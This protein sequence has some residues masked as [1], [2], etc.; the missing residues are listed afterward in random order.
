MRCG[1]LPAQVLTVIFALLF[2]TIASAAPV[3]W[4][5]SGVQF[6]DGGMASGSFTYD[7][8]TD[9]LTVWNIEVTNGDFED[10]TYSNTNPTATAEAT[11]PDI[12]FTFTFPCP[13]E[14][15]TL[16]L[17]TF[18]PLTNAGGT[19]GLQTEETLGSNSRTTSEGSLTGSIVPPPPPPPPPQPRADATSVGLRV[20]LANTVSDPVVLTTGAYAYAQ[21]LIRGPGALMSFGFVVHYNS[22]EQNVTPLGRKWTH[23]YNWRLENLGN[24]EW[25]VKHGD[26]AAD[27]YDE[28]GNQFTPQDPGV[29]ETLVR[30]GDGSFTYTTV[31]R[32]KFNFSPVGKLTS[33]VDSNL[34]TSQLTYDSNGDLA[35]VTDAG[36]KVATFSYNADDRITTVNYA[37]LIQVGFIYDSAGDLVTYTEPG[38]LTTTFTYDA[39]GNLLTAAA[40]GVQFVTNTY[41]SDKVTQQLDA[42]GEDSLITYS[43]NPTAA[44]LTNRLGDV[45]DREFDAAD[46]LSS[47]IDLRGVEWLFEYDAD[48]NDIRTQGPV[49]NVPLGDVAQKTYDAR[50]NLLT[51][52]DALNNTVIFTYDGNDNV[53]SVTDPAGKTAT[54]V[55]DA[56]DNLIRATD[57]LG[58]TASFIYTQSGIRGLVASSTDENGHTTTQTYTAAGDLAAVTDPLGFTVRFAYDGLGR[59]TSITDANNHTY[60]FGYDTA[61]RAVSYTTPLGEVGNFTYDPRGLLL[62]ERDPD[63][64]TTRYTYT[65]TGEIAS[66]TDPLGFVRTYEYDAEDRPIVVTNPAGRQTSFQWSARSELTQ[67]TDALGGETTATYDLAGNRTSVTDPN[68][69]TTSFDYDALGRITEETDPLGNKVKNE[70]NSRGLLESLTN[71]Q[72]EKMLFQ[73]DDA[74]RR[75]K[76][77]WSDNTTVD[78]VWDPAGNL[79]Q[80]IRNGSTT[81]SLTYDAN[82]DI[83]SRTDEFGKTIQYEYDAGGNMVK[84]TYSD[85]KAVHYRYDALNRLVE[86]RDWANRVTTYTYDAMGSLTT[87][88]LPDGSTVNYGYDAARRLTS[89]TDAAANGATIYRA[90]STL[91]AAGLKTKEQVQLPL[92]PT[93][94][95]TSVDRLFTYNAANQL[96]TENGQSFVHDPDGN[97]TGGAIAIT[98]PAT[99]LAYNEANQITQVGGAGGDSYEYDAAGLRIEATVAEKT[100]CYVWDVNSDYFANVLEEHDCNGNVTV[101]YVYGL[102]LISREDDNNGSVSVYHFDSRGSTV[103]LTNLAGQMT[104]RYAYDPYGRITNRNGTTPNPFTYN[105]RDGVIDDGNG[106]Y[107]MRVR[108]YVP[109]L[110]Q[111]AQAEAMV[112]GSLMRPASLNRYA[113]VYGNPIDLVDPAGDNP[114]LIAA[115]AGAGTGATIGV[116]IQIASNFQKACN[117]TVAKVAKQTWKATKSVGKAGVK[118]VKSLFSKKKKKKKPVKISKVDPLRCDLSAKPGGLFYHT[119]GAALEGAIT[120]GLEPFAI[121][122][123]PLGLAAAGAVGAAAGNALNQGLDIHVFHTQDK[124]NATDFGINV[125]FG[126]AGGALAGGLGKLGNA[127]PEGSF[128]KSVLGDVTD[129]KTLRIIDFGG[130]V[131]LASKPAKFI[132]K[133]I[134]FGIKQEGGVVADEVPRFETLRAL[135]K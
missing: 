41:N 68:G 124:F 119:A 14:N 122:G 91:D 96:A 74:G 12:Q 40:D 72:G 36:G 34:N 64:A 50:G 21:E 112:R 92:W 79:I 32:D 103:A 42:K 3:T 98:G 63:G 107:F 24:D 57:P 133:G 16:R 87:K 120:G 33:I 94:T 43:T 13:S 62:S 132:A 7:A 100:T 113:F 4:T 67:T 131:T 111:F 11:I 77:T 90:K 110:M 23:S 6:G 48:G 44:T 49:A 27:Y 115:A 58:R 85:G 109:A 9:M 105:G 8:D 28:V 128:V 5:L 102:G 18:Q 129:T 71:A 53:A 106:L 61:G 127:A 1:R 95:L 22:G 54:L 39:N 130:E 69:N 56:N 75:Q 35:T 93:T 2:C 135:S 82:D 84:L 66:V 78:H 89:I 25:R 65:P 30:N 97:L 118:K 47:W 37:G 73:Y 126:A 86:V 26:G 17:D 60:Q 134:I 83:T 81:T 117:T 80:L 51:I 101:R 46:R 19:V 29:F 31:E 114:L 70:F 88:R 52:T 104:D 59:N 121:A 108:A 125:G 38:N 20:P 123:G 76:T 55:Y 116:S 10:C 99:T 45:E 15:R